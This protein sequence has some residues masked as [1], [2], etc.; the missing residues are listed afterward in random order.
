MKKLFFLGFAAA[1]IAGPAMAADLATKASTYQAPVAAAF[2]WTGFYVGGHLGEGWEE[3]HVTNVGTINSA[4]FPFGATHKISPSGFLGGVQGG[5]NWQFSPNWLIGVEGDFSWADVKGEASSA[6]A[7]SLAVVSHY[8]EKV[9]WIS[10]F[11]GRIGYV[12]NNWLLYGKAGWGWADTE[13][14]SYTTNA[15]GAITTTTTSGETR[16]GWVAGGGVEWGFLP[17]W[18]VKLEYDYLELGTDTTSSAVTY[19]TTPPVLTGVTLL[20]EHDTHI[21][22]L[23]AGINYRF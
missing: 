12:S 3:D 8:N 1:T 4:N 10:T 17:N 14:S 6:G 18:T 23:K 2:N 16:S 22:L 9:N 20:R 19:G 21:N 13:G 7:V 11:T 15:A 5:F